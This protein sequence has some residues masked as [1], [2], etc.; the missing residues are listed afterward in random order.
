MEM[1]AKERAMQKEDHG[2][3]YVTVLCEGAIFRLYKPNTVN[4]IIL[5]VKKVHKKDPMKRASQYEVHYR[6]LV[7]TGNIINAGIPSGARVE[8]KSAF[9]VV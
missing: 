7:L 4:D 8:V 2:D 3:Y 9:C 6:G 1:S 5:A